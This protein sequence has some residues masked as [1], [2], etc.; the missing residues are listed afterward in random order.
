[1]CLL[2]YRLDDVA[3]QL[4]VDLV[5]AITNAICPTA[6]CYLQSNTAQQRYSKLSLLNCSLITASA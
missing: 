5:A 3:G 4:N 2:C 1:M 6:D